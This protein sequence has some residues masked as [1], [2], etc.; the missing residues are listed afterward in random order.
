MNNVRPIIGG[1]PYGPDIKKLE[2]TFPASSLTIGRT[3]QK[4]EFASTIHEE[5]GT[6]RCMGVWAAF[7]KRML[8]DHGVVLKPEGEAIRV[9]DDND[10]VDAVRGK[11]KTAARHVIGANRIGA[12]V[13]RKKLDEDRAR[14]L[15]VA[16][17]A[18]AG[19]LASARLK[20]K[21]GNP[22]IEDFVGETK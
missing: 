21:H 18:A 10:R 5:W 7:K 15:E 2:E 1:V 13:D 22:T 6:N 20:P 17:R 12:T 4:D 16:E 9:L 14:S 11:L 3:I 19:M 8:S